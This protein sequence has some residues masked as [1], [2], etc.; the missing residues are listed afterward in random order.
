MRTLRVVMRTLQC[1]TVWCNCNSRISGWNAR[2][3][4]T[5]PGNSLVYSFVISFV[6]SE[7]QMHFFFNVSY[8]GQFEKILQAEFHLFKLKARFHDQ[9]QPLRGVHLIEVKFTVI[10]HKHLI[11]VRCLAMILNYKLEMWST[12]LVLSRT[13]NFYCR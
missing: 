1:L 11:L 7:H 12:M 2:K 3:T 13:L 4:F 9:S 6:D 5:H 10:L 8:I